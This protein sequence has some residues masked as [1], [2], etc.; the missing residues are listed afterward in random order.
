[1]LNEFSYSY[2]NLLSPYAV[3]DTKNGNNMYDKHCQQQQLLLLLLL[4]VLYIHC[5]P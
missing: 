2:K 5:E 1:L 3:V 4:L